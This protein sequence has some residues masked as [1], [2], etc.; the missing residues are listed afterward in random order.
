[1]YLENFYDFILI[2]YTAFSFGISDFVLHLIQKSYYLFIYL[3][4]LLLFKTIIF[5]NPLY[6][7]QMKLATAAEIILD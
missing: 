1:M 3:L 2:F 7:A 6:I 5:N 4:L